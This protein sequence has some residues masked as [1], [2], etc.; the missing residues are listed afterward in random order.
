MNENII[1][2][3]NEK[4]FDR[5][6]NLSQIIESSHKADIKMLELINNDTYNNM[7]TV[8]LFDYD[9]IERGHSAS[10]G[11]LNKPSQMNLVFYFYL[12]IILDLKSFGLNK[13]RLHKIKTYLF[14]EISIL[15][16]LGGEA[17]V[18]LTDS[19][20]I[21]LSESIKSFDFKEPKIKEALLQK[22]ESGEFAKDIEGKKLSVLFLNIFKLIS[23]SHD[24]YLLIDVNMDAMFI[25][26]TELSNKDLIDL[27]KESRII[28]PLKQYLL[29]FMGEYTNH[30]FIS[31]AKLLNDNDI[32]VLEQ[33]KQN[34]IESVS[35]KFHN[36]KPN[37]MEV[38]KQTKIEIQSRLS[39]VLLKGG[40]EDIV[41][42]TKQGSIYYSQLTTKTKF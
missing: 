39:D 31:R 7:N 13:T 37:V 15:E 5:L 36:G 34:D 26:E 16:E 24:I 8:G 18:P 30:S 3:F 17:K 10:K 29:N 12:N 28:I 42:K 33:L 38:K 4:Y 41:L 40:F 32:M 1:N 20:T 14:E 25:D 27:A 11:I 6:I 2:Y 23:V 9:Y 35:I 19:L 21:S 22:I